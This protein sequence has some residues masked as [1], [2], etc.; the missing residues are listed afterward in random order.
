MLAEEQHLKFPSQ[1]KLFIFFFFCYATISNHNGLKFA[2]VDQLGLCDTDSVFG[3]VLNIINYRFEIAKVRSTNFA[4]RTCPSLLEEIR[5]HYHILCCFC[6]VLCVVLRHYP[7]CISGQCL[8]SIEYLS[9]LQLWVIG[10]A[11]SFPICWW[12]RSSISVIFDVVAV[13]EIIGYFKSSSY[14]KWK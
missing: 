14:L 7:S 10:S 13:F 11:Y 6:F 5:N 9:W 1:T 12:F 8:T 4:I 2:P 3:Y